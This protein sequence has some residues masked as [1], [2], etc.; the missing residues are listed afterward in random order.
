MIRFV[1]DI[2]FCNGFN[3]IF[4]A[5]KQKFIDMKDVLPDK[6]KERDNNTEY[7]LNQMETIK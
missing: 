5:Y 1:K 7:F 4:K 6:D 3:L 2:F